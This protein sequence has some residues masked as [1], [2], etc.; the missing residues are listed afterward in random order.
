MQRNIYLPT[1]LPTYLYLVARHNPECSLPTLA[2][3]SAC[4]N[5]AHDVEVCVAAHTRA[6]TYTLALTLYLSFAHARSASRKDN[7]VQQC[8]NFSTQPR[9]MVHHRPRPHLNHYQTTPLQRRPLHCPCRVWAAAPA[10]AGTPQEALLPQHPKPASPSRGF[11]QRRS[12]RYSCHPR[13]AGGGLR[14]A[15]CHAG[16]A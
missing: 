5:A 4:P 6:H 8:G 11:L 3:C 7:V 2:V 1:Y 9:A 15:A 12:P 16:A 14:L 13:P 10:Q